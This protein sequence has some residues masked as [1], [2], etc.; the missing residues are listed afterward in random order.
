MYPVSTIPHTKENDIFDLFTFQIYN[1]YI[2]NFQRNTMFT[3]Y[4]IHYIITQNTI[5]LTVKFLVKLSTQLQNLMA[6]R[7][8]IVQ[9]YNYYARRE[10]YLY[11]M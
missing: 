1:F 5:C 6:L 7:R 2:I 8:L 3:T 11:I 9:T 10:M 4:T